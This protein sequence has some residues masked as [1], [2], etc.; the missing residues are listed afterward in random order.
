MAQNVACFSRAN[1]MTP[2]Q[3]AAAIKPIEKA[4]VVDEFQKLLHI[5]SSQTEITSTQMNSA[6]GLKILDFYTFVERL[7]TQGKHGLNFFEFLHQLPSIKKKKY[8]QNVVKFY[9]DKKPHL[10]PIKM[11]YNIFSL[12]F[13]AVNAFK[14]LVA[15][16]IYKIH[17]NTTSL[18]ILDFT[19]GFGG[20]L[21]GACAVNAKTYIGIDLNTNL[22]A[23]INK[24]KTLLSKYSPTHVELI[25]KDA[26]TV[27]YS[28][29]KYNFVLTS[30][31]YYGIETYSHMN[32]YAD[33]NDWD[34]RFY[35]PVF[36]QT[37]KHMA[38]GGWYCINVNEEIYERVCKPV[39]GPI[40]HK[41]PL[42]TSGGNT[43]Q[44]FTYCWKKR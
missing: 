31:P 27:D 11:W 21:V 20:R 32:V 12:Y 39:L 36:T 42:P 1:T 18:K 22:R 34:A 3:I 26:T 15:M 37:Y 19:M 38:R 44:E 28:K 13:G 25:F 35:I 2:E 8:I 9:H 33:K 30:P 23:P 6:L 4:E 10:P 40:A 43:Y 17:T 14:P 16:N 7:N 29:L 41:I 24:I 5:A